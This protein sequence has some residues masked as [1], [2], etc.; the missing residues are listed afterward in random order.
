MKK[1]YAIVFLVF[2]SIQGFSQKKSKKSQTV[3]PVTVESTFSPASDR[4]TAH[5]NR[6][7]LGEKS[8]VKNVKFRSVGPTVMSGRVADIDVNDENP[9]EFYVAYATGGL[10][11]TTNNGQSFSPIFDNQ[12]VATLGD[13]AVDWKSKNRIIWAGT[14]ESISSRSSYAGIGVFKSDDDGKTW[15]HKGLDETH[16][17]GEIKLHP[18]DPN[19]VWVAALG[20]LYTPNKERGIFKTS[21]GGTTWKNTLYVDENTGAIDIQIDSTNPKIL[22]A[23]MW[24]KSRRAWNFEEGGLGTGIYKSIDGGDTWAN[25]TLQPSGFPQGSTNG[26]VGI[27]VSPTNPNLLYAVL[28]NQAKQVDFQKKEIL[29]LDSKKIKTLTKEQFLALPNTEINEYLDDERFPDKYNAKN[30]KEDIKTNKYLVADIAKFTENANDDL[31]NT[32]II[33]AEVFRSENGGTTWTRTHKGY[34]EAVFNTYGYV[35]GT[36]HVAPNNPDKI[37]IPGYQIIKSEDGGKTFEGINAPNVHADHHVIWINPKNENHMILGNDGGL[38][39]T[40]DN[41]KNWIFANTPALGMFYAIQVDMATPYNVY[42]GL[43]DNGVWVGPSTYKAD[44]EWYSTGNYP[45]KSL[46]GGDGMQVEVDTR[47]NNTVYTGFQFGNYFKINK[48]TGQRKYL[49]M[50]QE[51]GETKNRFNWLS[52]ILLSQFNQDIIYFGG[53]RLFRSTDKGEKWE[54]ISSDLTKGAKVGDVPYGTITAI[55]ESPKKLGLIYVGTDDGNVQ[56]S[57]D[58]GYN[59]TN[60]SEKLPQNLWVS[61]VIASKYKDSKVI[62]SLNGY[63][64]DDFNSY[65][66][67]SDDYGSNWTK[68]GENLPKEAINVVREDPKNADIMYVGTDHGLYVSIN[69]GKTFMAMTNGIPNIPVHDLVV[70]S[71]DN[72][73]VVGTHGRSIY[74]ANIEHLQQFHENDSLLNK[75][76]TL[77]ALKPITYTERW[78]RVSGDDKY[79]PVKSQEY[80]IPYYAKSAGTVKFKILSNARFLLKEW[81]SKVD[82]GLNY[83]NWDLSIDPNVM[84]DYQMQLNGRRKNSDPNI[85][86]EKADD[87]KVY[88]RPGKY[89][90]SL[91][92][93]DGKKIEKEFEVKANERTSKRGS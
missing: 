90:M 16:H 46:L 51:I 91:E 13:I 12:A 65:L 15:Q 7:E 64:N 76:L 52:P 63:R 60:I 93:S 43:Q 57:K 68:I 14:G 8:L 17:I 44:N 82:A 92:T 42:G 37:V 29:K 6:L 58:A 30:L 71:R 67:K 56:V 89:F 59:F 21:D 74:I 61:R 25:I 70:H 23:C 3:K 77:F 62:V 69:Q 45:Y 11:K 87:G 72:E 20:H 50:P 41:G 10:W 35:F 84:F 32:P 53:N 31:F 18:T 47:D 36:V 22:Y 49:Q 80:S 54:A 88:I 55:S 34:L 73:L 39:I 78:G 40:Y 38:N 83:D 5:K 66:Y 24:Q 75:D 33:G 79:N 9:T 19:T 2:V 27:A 85:V 26:R 48:A 81:E 1:K 86:L 28:D 4:W